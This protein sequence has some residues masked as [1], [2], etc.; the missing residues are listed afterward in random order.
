MISRF[1]LSNDILIAP[2][3]KKLGGVGDIDTAKYM[4][5]LKIFEY[6]CLQEKLSSHLTTKF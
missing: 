2:Y 4:S 1:L 5:P 6:I 3:Q